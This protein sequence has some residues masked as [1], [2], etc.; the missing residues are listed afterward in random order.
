MCYCHRAISL[1]RHNIC[2][3]PIL[4][5]PMTPVQQYSIPLSV[6]EVPQDLTLKMILIIY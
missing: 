4:S 5:Y 6:K 3:Y 2:F 1:K